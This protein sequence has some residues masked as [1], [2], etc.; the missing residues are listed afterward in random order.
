ME[1]LESV[2]S[3]LFNVG[4]VSRTDIWHFCLI[5]I[6]RER[7]KKKQKSDMKRLF[8]ADVTHVI[9]QTYRFQGLSAA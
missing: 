1:S 9:I 8:I 2:N 3:A 4:K 6:E 5:N 7:G